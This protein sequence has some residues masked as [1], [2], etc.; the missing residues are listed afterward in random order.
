ML[1]GLVLCLIVRLGCIVVLTFGDRGH[2]VGEVSH[3]PRF[4]E[5]LENLKYF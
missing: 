3:P 5:F 1:Y 2:G 4:C